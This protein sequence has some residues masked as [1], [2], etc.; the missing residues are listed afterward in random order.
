MTPAPAPMLGSPFP[1]P[2]SGPGGMMMPGASPCGLFS[3]A[4]ATPGLAGG[5]LATP[6]GLAATDTSPGLAN[7]LAAGLTGPSSLTPFVSGSQTSMDVDV[8]G[9]DEM[10][11]LQ[12][13]QDAEGLLQQPLLAPQP[14]QQPLPP[15]QQQEGLQFLHQQPLPLQE[16]PML[17]PMQLPPP[18]QPQQQPQELQQQQQQQQE[19]ELDLFDASDLFS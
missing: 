18:Q 8:K 19:L 5:A 11:G 15:Q 4:L 9:F 7:L 2:G 13:S 10:L 12:P 16:V 6:G 17:L 1:Q 14:L 3:A